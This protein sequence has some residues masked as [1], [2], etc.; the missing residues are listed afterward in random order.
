MML[1]RAGRAV[2]LALIVV[3]GSAVTGASHALPGATLLLS[4]KGDKL[5]LE[6]IVA[7]E[8][9][10]IAA[11]QLT[12]LK[13]LPMGPI[14]SDMIASNVSTYFLTHL[15]LQQ[16]GTALAFAPTDSRLAPDENEHVGAFTQL[17]LTFSAPKMD[18]APLFPMTLLYDA[19]MHEVR[20]HR[21]TVFW[22]DQNDVL[23]RIAEFGFRRIDGAPQPI[24][25]KLPPS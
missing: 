19:V 16:A 5:E 9:L 17:V 15:E 6:I 18:A 7:V 2:L 25:L 10:I 21:A 1:V 12:P 23:S 4:Q 24:S 14:R 8:D 22:D 3:M 20:N 13:D 11:P